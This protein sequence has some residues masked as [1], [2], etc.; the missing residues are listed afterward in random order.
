LPES[1]L[2]H[3]DFIPIV[4]A[5]GAMA[6]WWDIFQIDTPMADILYNGSVLKNNTTGNNVKFTMS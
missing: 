3:L 6:A 4:Y 5:T 2:C 1:A